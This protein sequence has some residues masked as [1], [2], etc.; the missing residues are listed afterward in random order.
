MSDANVIC[1]WT[2]SKCALVAV[3]EPCARSGGL[4][5]RRCTKYCSPRDDIP[6]VFSLDSVDAES[7]S[8]LLPRAAQIEIPNFSAFERNFWS[9]CKLFKGNLALR[10]NFHDLDSM[11]ANRVKHR[12]GVLCFALFVSLYSVMTE[13]QAANQ[14]VE[15]LKKTLSSTNTVVRF[16]MMLSHYVV[17]RLHDA[18]KWRKS[19]LMRPSFY[20]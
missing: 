15:D 20:W 8:S 12:S 2:Q 1:P 3:F 11:G 18:S 19:K 10:Q 16:L 5:R 7:M 13:H 17:R 14:D 9:K 6:R 4:S